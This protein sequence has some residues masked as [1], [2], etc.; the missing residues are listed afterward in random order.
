MS[1]LQIRLLPLGLLLLIHLG[2]GGGSNEPTT[3]EVSGKVTL[4][5]KPVENGLIRF[6]PGSG[7]PARDPNVA[8]ITSGNYKAMVTAGSKRVEIEVYSPTGPVFDGKPTDEQIAP[9]K[10]NTESTLK[11]DIQS[12]KNPDIDFTLE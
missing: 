3:Y 2:C 12:G 10:Y 1:C 11:K 5:G 7:E 9:P 4:A 6:V 8:P